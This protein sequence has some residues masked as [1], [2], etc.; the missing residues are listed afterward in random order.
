MWSKEKS[1][2]IRTVGW[3]VGRSERQTDINVVNCITQQHSNWTYKYILKTSRAIF[4]AAWLL[5]AEYLE[6]AKKLLISFFLNADRVMV[7]VFMG[8]IAR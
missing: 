6:F 4:I 7:G 5:V 3:S 2:V 8:F 1:A